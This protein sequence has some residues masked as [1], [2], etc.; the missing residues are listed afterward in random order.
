MDRYEFLSLVL[1]SQSFGTYVSHIQLTTG[2]RFNT[3]CPTLQQLADYC[4][5][6]S[7]LGHTLYFALGAFQNNLEYNEETGRNKCLRTKEFAHAFK[8]IAL[9]I[10]CGEG[11]PYATQAEGV[12]ALKAFLVHTKLPAPLLNS[13]GNGLHC[14]WPLENSI[15]RSEWEQITTPLFDLVSALDFKVDTSKI[16]DASMVLRPL[17]TTNWKKTGAKPVQCLTPAYSTL[18]KPDTLRG[19]ITT[20]LP[21]GAAKTT[22]RQAPASQQLSPLMQAAMASIEKDSPPAIGSLIESRCAAVQRG[23]FEGGKTADEPLWYALMGMSAF[24]ENREALVE[25]WAGGHPD[26][27]LEGSIAKGNQWLKSTD[28]KPPVCAHFETLVPSACANCKYK[29]KIT[30][31]LQT[32]RP[33]PK[34]VVS[35]ANDPRPFAEPQEPFRRTAKGVIAIVD[36]V[37]LTVLDYDMF[38]SHIIIDPANDYEEI[39]WVWKKPHMGHKRIRIR[40]GILFGDSGSDVIKALGDKGIMVSDKAQQQRVSVYMKAYARS[41]QQYQE[42]VQL[43]NAFGWKHDG[44]SFVLG[45]TEFYR[46]PDGTVEQR[47]TGVA[48]AI[49]DKGL[50]SRVVPKGDLEKWKTWTGVFKAPG[51]ELH[52]L[53]L[54]VAFAAPLLRFTGLHGFCISLLGESG[55]G[56]SLA[57]DWC[58]SVYGDPRALGMKKEDTKLSIVQRMG[59]MSNMPVTL[60]EMSLAEPDFVQ[61]VT[62]WSTQGQDKN[63]AT[64]AVANFWQLPMLMNSNKSIVDKIT[65]RNA[66]C[67]PILMRLLEFSVS[68]PKLLESGD[69]G[70]RMAAALA[71]NHGLAGREYIRFL[72]EMGPVK[73]REEIEL[74]KH[75][76]ERHYNIEF[77]GNERYW[78]VAITLMDLGLY[79][80]DKAGLIQF[81]FHK[82]IEA[83]V[84]GVKESR[85][86]VKA[87]NNDAFDMVSMILNENIG[88][89]I[90]VRYNADGF[91]FAPAPEMLPRQEVFLRKEIYMGKNST[92]TRGFMYFDRGYLRSWLVNKGYDFNKL[93]IGLQE[94]HALY[95]PSKNGMVSMGKDSPLVLGRV[96]CIGIDLSHPRFRYMLD[97]HEDLHDLTQE[98]KIKV[99]EMRAKAGG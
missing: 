88:R 52:Q 68:T 35:G 86:S 97:A 83:A 72:L 65:V 13:S 6:Q 73:L 15:P 60:D 16:K 53:G 79:F 11:K 78:A 43:Y 50:D 31:P 2:P 82:G 51:M 56:K 62:Y 27:T 28:G 32:G 34:A 70:Y 58:N 9:D 40:S 22:T 45:A 3:H 99:V 54:G 19:I 33:E 67:E 63:R 75:Y 93:R 37:A 39:E 18:H 57:L 59:I 55:A 25:K 90:T 80:A 5:N 17:D 92:I 61:D 94:D 23:A 98:D 96:S 4:A 24:C 44:N 69:W 84:A 7:A 87:T 41:L 71:E 47:E 10:D 85:T 74:R 38:P 76:V 8:T 64:E 1:P 14:Y 66:D 30:T 36:G 95:M 29:G 20:A 46:K 21:K 49:T 42:T 81:D 89:T 12:A 48:K 77:K 26:Y 91:P